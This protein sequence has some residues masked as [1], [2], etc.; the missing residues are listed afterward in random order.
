MAYAVVAIGTN[1]RPEYHL[2]AALGHL[3]QRGQLLA[4][5]RV[6]ETP[7]VGAPGTPF[8]LNA[9]VLVR[10]DDPPERF[11]VDVLRPVEQI[12]GRRRTHDPNAPRTIDLDLIL[13]ADEGENVTWWDSQLRRYAHV[14]LPVADVVPN[15]R[16]PANE[17][18]TVGEIAQKL[19]PQ[20]RAF[21]RRVDVEQ[22][23]RARLPGVAFPP[24]AS[25]Q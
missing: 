25:D 22:R 6:Y 17:G 12:L 24:N 20:A 13:Y 15:W 23:L 11:I 8:F 5:S 21:R 18:L 19:L 16:L 3:S 1:I 2:E 10:T 9:A 14:A 4:I 7:P